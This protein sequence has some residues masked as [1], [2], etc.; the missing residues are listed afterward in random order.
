MLRLLTLVSLACVALA[1]D[2][3]LMKV[4]TYLMNYILD[5]KRQ[6]IES[7]YGVPV[8]QTNI[9]QSGTSQ[10]VSLL[11]LDELEDSLKQSVHNEAVVAHVLTQVNDAVRTATDNPK[12]RSDCS[13]ENHIQI[14]IPPQEIDEF[15]DR[16]QMLIQQNSFLLLEQMNTLFAFKLRSL[17]S[18]LEKVIKR[19]Y[20]ALES[21]LDLI[22]G[23]LGVEMPEEPKPTTDDDVDNPVTEMP[24]IITDSVFPSLVPQPV[25]S[26]EPEPVA[27][28][29]PFPQ[30]EPTVQPAPEPIAEPVTTVQPAPEPFAEP[31]PT[32][33]PDPDDDD[34]DDLDFTERPDDANDPT[35][36]DESSDEDSGSSSGFVR[37]PQ[38]PASV[39]SHSGFG[40]MR[41]I[42]SRPFT[43]R[44]V[45]RPS[46]F[47]R[48]RLETHRASVASHRAQRR[49]ERIPQ[50]SALDSRYGELLPFSR[51]VPTRR[52]RISIA[53]KEY[54][55]ALRSGAL[56]MGF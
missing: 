48:D 36:G 17:K 26:P 9:K 47:W 28:P 23:A 12:S 11:D 53:R 8:Y 10:H 1:D 44:K 45:Q 56:Y 50:R 43:R 42:V 37:T 40:F 16:V 27:T 3:E 49:R 32:S 30:P 20:N 41:P 34:D 51:P 55:E 18:D 13:V 29:G 4:P 39:V 54:Q 35:S 33:R 19:R 22:M 14:A 24:E 25:P 38:Q 6:S 15:N 46:S 7:G 31:E 21:K 5:C 2:G 52:D